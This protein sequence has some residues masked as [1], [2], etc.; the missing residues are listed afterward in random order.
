MHAKQD[1][2]KIRAFS[3]NRCTPGLL[4]RT[5]TIGRR[6]PTRAPRPPRIHGHG[7]KAVLRNGLLP[8]PGDLPSVANLFLL[9]H[10][11]A[12]IQRKRVFHGEISERSMSAKT[13]SI[14]MAQSFHVQLRRQ[15]SYLQSSRQ[16]TFSGFSIPSILIIRLTKIRES[17][18]PTV[19]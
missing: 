17:T 3:G 10:L 13:T 15:S 9:I 12:R 11:S 14:L 18:A 2:P 19:T 1:H 16:P 5:T 4:S 8:L 7:R 6:R